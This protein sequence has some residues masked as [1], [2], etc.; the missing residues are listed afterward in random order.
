MVDMAINKKKKQAKKSKKEKKINIK[1]W[2]T[3][4]K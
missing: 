4:I 2:K 1:L 3:K